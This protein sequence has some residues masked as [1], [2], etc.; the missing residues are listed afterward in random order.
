M[1][2][3]PPINDGSTFTSTKTFDPYDPARDVLILI[4]L[5]IQQRDSSGNFRRHFPA[6]FSEAGQEGR[7]HLG[8]GGQAAVFRHDAHEPAD[9]IDCTGFF[10]HGGNRL[11]LIVAAQHSAGH[12]PDGGD[13]P[14]RPAA[15]SARTSIHSPRHRARL[16]SRPNHRGLRHAAR[17]RPSALSPPRLVLSFTVRRARLRLKPDLD[18]GPYALLP[19]Q[20]CRR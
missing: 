16:A 9:E 15:P 3:R 19:R 18:R 6:L 13:L 12:H 2:T 17:Q 4:D 7:N 11:R 14:T 10:Q 20:G 1:T 8:Q 5:I